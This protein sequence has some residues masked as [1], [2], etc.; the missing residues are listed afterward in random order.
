MKID[1]LDVSDRIKRAL[2]SPGFA[3]QDK[4]VETVEQL[5]SFSAAEI[6]RTPDLGPVGQ[7]RLLKAVMAAGYQGFGVVTKPRIRVK[8]GRSVV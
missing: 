5:C 7:K 4:G 1:E 6:D 3:L 2:K 8:M